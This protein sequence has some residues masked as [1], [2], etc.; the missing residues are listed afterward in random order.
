MISIFSQYLSLF[1]MLVSSICFSQSVSVALPHEPEVVR[2]SDGEWLVYDIQIVS[3]HQI[4]PIK[5]VIF[6]GN[7]VE[8]TETG[9][10]KFNKDSTAYVQ[11]IWIKTKNKPI[12]ELIHKFYFIDKNATKIITKRILVQPDAPKKIDW[13][14]EAGK[15]IAANAPGIR[16]EHTNTTVKVGDKT[17]DTIQ[18]AWILGHNNQRFAIDFVK[19]DNQGKLF[20]NDG[21]SNKDWFSYGSPIKAATEGK[22]VKVI[23]SIEDNSIPGHIDY[24]ITKD[25][26]GGNCIFIDIGND[27]IAF[28][29]HL[30]KGSIKVKEGDNVEKGQFLGLL[31]NSGQ[32]T[33]P[34]LHFHLVTSNNIPID[35]SINGFMYEGIPYYF[36][37]FDSYGKADTNFWT[38][39]SDG[40]SIIAPF[41]LGKA[42]K[43]PNALPSNF[44]VIKIK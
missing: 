7:E 18:K 34:H 37:S 6:N 23:D 9:F 3:E 5:S 4:Q 2:N 15:W 1:L 40:K 26:I 27:K 38:E 14:I 44:E 21:S 13:P 8:F 16:S 24:K 12:T 36:E 43:I 39:T 25:N 42:I 19:M 32:T 31:G 11:Y 33:A 22:V 29:G 17:Y 30:Q 28:Y 20:A 35:Y 41:H 10:Q